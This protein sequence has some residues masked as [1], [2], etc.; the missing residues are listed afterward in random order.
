MRENTLKKALGS[1]GDR[2]ERLAVH[3]SAFSAEVMAHQGFDSL[4]HRHAARSDRLSG[5]RRHACGICTTPVVRSRA[6]PGTIPPR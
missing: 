1:R 3:S 6:C 4:V 5:S 2:C